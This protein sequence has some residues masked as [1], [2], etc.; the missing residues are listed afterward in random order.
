MP[1][2]A[3]VKRWESEALLDLT[4]ASVGSV[5]VLQWLFCVMLF[6]ASSL[7]GEPAEPLNTRV[8]TSGRSEVY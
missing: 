6:R 4:Q 5:G 3:Q 8:D 1:L 7:H 2:G